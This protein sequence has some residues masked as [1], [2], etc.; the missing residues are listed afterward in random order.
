M[1]NQII[2]EIQ[3]S[4]DSQKQNAYLIPVLSE[5]AKM[6]FPHLVRVEA[7]R[8]NPI[9]HHLTVLQ[10]VIQ[11]APSQENFLHHACTLA[12][13][14]DSSAQPKITSQEIESLR[15]GNQEI[16][17]I[18]ET[19][20]HLNRLL[21]MSEGS[22]HVLNAMNAVNHS[23]HRVVY[24]KVDMFQISYAVFHHDLLSLN[25][26]IPDNTL[27]R[28]F[29]DCDVLWFIAFNNEEGAIGPKAD[30]WR[31]GEDIENNSALYDQLIKNLRNME[32]RSIS[33]FALNPNLNPKLKQIYENY[34]SEWAKYFDTTVAELKNAAFK[35]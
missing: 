31:R 24:N 12:L 16:A 7:L 30:L 23:L 35:K 34:L 8:I 28:F 3:L 4:L 26:K 9:S 15:Q 27:L 5:F 13:G 19:E 2:S 17:E 21:H 22:V 14:H 33:G 29:I 11:A 10:H 1:L 20:R 25:Q 32:K 18:R 6:V